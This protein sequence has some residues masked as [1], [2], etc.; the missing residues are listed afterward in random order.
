[1]E[2]VKILVKA[3][4]NP[5]ESSMKVQTAIEQVFGAIS[6]RRASSLD[7][8]FL[9]AQGQG[10]IWLEKLRDLICKERI[11]TAARR[12]LLNSIHCGTLCFYL[13]KQVAFI[14]RLSFSEE[15][16]GSSL[17]SITVQ[18]EGADPEKMVDWLAPKF[19]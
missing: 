19:T 1:V 12:I 11:Q 14:G 5:T 9:V 18:L 2:S 15:T 16:S 10:L 7:Q 13:N 6:I 17:G 3:P 4:V 8:T